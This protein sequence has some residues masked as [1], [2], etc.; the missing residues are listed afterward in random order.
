[1]LREII[2][3]AIVS[4]PQPQDPANLPRLAEDIALAAQLHDGAPFVGPARVEAL[5]M[6][7]VAIAY[8][9]SSFRHPVATCRI[10]GDRLPWQKAHDGRSI[11]LWQLMRGP[12]WDG[13]SRDELCWNQSLAAYVAAKVLRRYARPWNWGGLFRGYASGSAGRDS[14]QARARCKTWERVSRKAGLVVSCH[15]RAEVRLAP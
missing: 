4:L 13:H 14:W 8:H 1:M 9:E 11:T 15:D 7:L 6:A 3:A 5:S 2:L 10:T 12:S